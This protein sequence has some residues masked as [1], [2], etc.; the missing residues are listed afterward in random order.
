MGKEILRK[1]GGLISRQVLEVSDDTINDIAY[2]LARL[3][4]L[5]VVNLSIIGRI[6]AK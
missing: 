4:R 2:R 5:R 3:A 6:V 1:E